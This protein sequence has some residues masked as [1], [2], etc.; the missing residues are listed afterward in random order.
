MDQ[1]SSTVILTYCFSPLQRKQ[2]MQIGLIFEYCD[3]SSL[4]KAMR[5]VCAYTRLHAYTRLQNN[6]NAVCISVFAASVCVW[7]T[8]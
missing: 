3:K 5:K 7:Q 1:F 8:R 6:Q 2:D 4:A